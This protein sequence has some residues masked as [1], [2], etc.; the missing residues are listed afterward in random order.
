MPVLD[1]N[2]LIALAD[3]DAKAQVLLEALKDQPLTVPSIV[4]AEFLAP[5]ANPGDVLRNLERSFQVKQTST[6]WIEEAARRR[7]E[8]AKRRASIRSADFW[9]ATWAH[10]ED[11]VVVTRNGR[12]FEALGVRTVSW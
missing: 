2:F 3:G 6:Q 10:L 12:D 5:Y 4:A 9:I 8:L 7:H 11:D 1:T